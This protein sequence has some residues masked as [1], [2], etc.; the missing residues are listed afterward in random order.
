MK[1][2]T[3][4]G[5]GPGDPEAQALWLSWGGRA[6]LDFYACSCPQVSRDGDPRE[7]SGRKPSLACLVGQL[8]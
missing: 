5:R 4:E 6:G 8:L 3:F 1:G 7:P 2:C